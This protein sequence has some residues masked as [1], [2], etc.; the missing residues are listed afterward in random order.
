MRELDE[1]EMRKVQ[2]GGAFCD[3]VGMYLSFGDAALMGAAEY[4]ATVA[5]TTVAMNAAGVVTV[6]GVA[7]AAYCGLS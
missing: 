4:A 1:G 5:T 3:A 6:A 7:V 2:G